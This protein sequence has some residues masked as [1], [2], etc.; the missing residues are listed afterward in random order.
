VNKEGGKGIRGR[1]ETLGKGTFGFGE[2]YFSY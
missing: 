2:H 1:G